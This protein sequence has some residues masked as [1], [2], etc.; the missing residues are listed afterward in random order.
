MYEF[1]SS[2]ITKNDRIERNL[3]DREKGTNQ[4]DCCAEQNEKHRRSKTRSFSSVMM[5]HRQIVHPSKNV[6]MRSL[7]TSTSFV[8]FPKSFRITRPFPKRYQIRISA[9]K[10]FGD[11]QNPKSQK[12][13]SYEKLQKEG[14]LDPRK[15]WAPLAMATDFQV[16][17]IHAILL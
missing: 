2:S 4:N 17:H 5:V 7:I 13:T 1:L 14:G 6:M 8:P 11:V 10:G 15:G 12:S 16:K 3:T 9:Q